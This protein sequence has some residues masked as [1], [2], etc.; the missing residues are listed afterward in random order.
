M[1]NHKKSPCTIRHGKKQFQVKIRTLHVIFIC[2][3][4]ARE[5]FMY[6]QNTGTLK[7]ITKSHML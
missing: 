1:V 4:F 6:K 7:I 3:C 5:I 2:A